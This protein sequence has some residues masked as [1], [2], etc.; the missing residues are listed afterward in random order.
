MS[1]DTQRPLVDGHA[2]GESEPQ[3]ASDDWNA[4]LK[5]AEYVAKFHGDEL[6]ADKQN[7]VT[8]LLNDIR[9]VFTFRNAKEIGTVGWKAFTGKGLDVS[10]AEVVASMLP[11]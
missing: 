7:V 5:K 10:I 3:V 1:S 4:E 11:R 6:L 8:G 2:V 9:N